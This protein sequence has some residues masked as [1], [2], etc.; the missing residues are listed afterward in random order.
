MVVFDL[1][2]QGYRVVLAHPERCPAFHRDRSILD[3]L[4]GG[5]VLTSVT[6]GSLVGRFG[7]DVRRFANELVRDGMVHNVASD[8]HDDVSRPPGTASELKEAGLTSLTDWLT[9]AVPQAIIAG[10][11]IPKHPQVEVLASR[12]GSRK[13]RWGLPRR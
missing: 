11:D 13:S 10:T 2:R 5:G 4:V 3:A 6:A 7:R 8:A 12:S 9:I 1:H